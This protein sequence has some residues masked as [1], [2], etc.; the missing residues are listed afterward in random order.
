MLDAV[1]LHELL[2][3]DGAGGHVDAE[4]EGLGGEDDLE[5]ASGEQLLDHGLQQRQHA[6]V[7]G[8]VA[9]HDP[10]SE[11][12][13]AQDLLVLDTDLGELLVEHGAD[14]PPLLVVGQP[15]PG[16]CAL[17]DRSLASGAGEDEHDRG[18]QRRVVEQLHDLR[19]AH[20][21]RAGTAAARAAALA[22]PAVRAS[23]MR[24]AAAV[25]ARGPSRLGT[26]RP[27][28]PPGAAGTVPA[29]GALAP[30][31]AA[32]PLPAGALVDREGE[33]GDPL[34]LGVDLSVRP[35]AGAVGDHRLPVLVDEEVQQLLPHD[36]VLPQRHGPRLG[37]DDLRAAAHLLQPGAE[38]LRVG[39]RRREGDELHGAVEV[40]D[41]L[42]PHGAAQAV[43]EV[44]HLVHHHEAQPVQQVG[45]RVQHVA[46][47]LGGHHDHLRIGADRGVTG[48]Q[49][50]P[51]RAEP[52]H[53]LAELLVR[54]RLDRGGV[55]HLAPAREGEVHGELAHD[56]LARSRRRG[57]E[58]RAAV[59]EGAPPGELEVVQRE[60]VAGGEGGQRRVGEAPLLGPGGVLLGG[61]AHCAPPSTALSSG[62]A[63][64]SASSLTA[65]G[66]TRAVTGSRDRASPSA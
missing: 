65:P 26:P 25:P 27:A 32:P 5:Q 16:P 66:S 23:A 33:G 57:D 8:G 3:H 48:E 52:V 1:E 21:A 11:G 34:D 41:D 14:L 2:E 20:R 64:R 30:P 58:H 17:L 12:C 60:G 29:A 55:E 39:D 35:C 10:A 9:V 31:I 40:D 63:V 13:Q 19:A 62:I 50:H 53:E 36:H 18:Q 54:Q 56:G 4:R 49:P 45:V 37:D 59:L 38:L 6:G 44:V 22:G 46:Q 42:L 51:V 47:H 28:V 15:Q 61:S 43:G 7:V 24:G